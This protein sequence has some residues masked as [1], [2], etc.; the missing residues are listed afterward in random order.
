MSVLESLC[1]EEIA[2]W[3]S[4]L[5]EPLKD[6]RRREDVRVTDP[7]PSSYGI[8]WI[9]PGPADRLQRGIEPRASGG[10][11]TYL[12]VE[13]AIAG[14]RELLSEWETASVPGYLF[15][16]YDGSLEVADA[17]MWVVVSS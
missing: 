11:L 14:T 6:L 5:P 1:R 2:R 15:I 12:K 13:T 4:T 17:L 3:I 16:V 10:R 8:R 7:I 9:D